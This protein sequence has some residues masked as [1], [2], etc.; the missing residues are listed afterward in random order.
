MHQNRAPGWGLTRIISP[1]ASNYGPD[2]DN[3]SNYKAVGAQSPSLGCVFSCAKALSLGLSSGQGGG[4]AV[5]SGRSVPCGSDYYNF[6]IK[7]EVWECDASVLFFYLRD[8]FEYSGSFV[9]PYKF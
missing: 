7:F 8:C 9:V 4:W 5:P 1:G 3:S 6:V 2:V